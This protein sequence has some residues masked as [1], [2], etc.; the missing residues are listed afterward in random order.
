M[1]WHILHIFDILLWLLLA[2]STLYILFFALVSILWKKHVNEFT[3]FLTGKKIAMRDK[4]FFTYLVLY[5]A[6]N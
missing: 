3:M 6:Y 1:L 5:P 2:A 4:E